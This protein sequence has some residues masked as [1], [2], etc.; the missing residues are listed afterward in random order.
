MVLQQTDTTR[1]Q[2]IPRLAPWVPCVLT[3][4]ILCECSGVSAPH[5]H[6]WYHHLFPSVDDEEIHLVIVVLHL[7]IHDRL[8]LCVVTPKHVFWVYIS[9]NTQK[10][11]IIKKTLKRGFGIRY[12]YHPILLLVVGA[13]LGLPENLFPHRDNH[14]WQQSTVTTM[15]ISQLGRG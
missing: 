8:S 14:W 12:Q 10:K 5:P 6:P 13:C 7:H 2:E 9:K 1:P 4:Q 11:L 15:E 3:K